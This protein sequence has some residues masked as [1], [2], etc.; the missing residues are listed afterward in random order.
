MK[1]LFFSPGYWQS[2]IQIGSHHLARSL[3]SLGW[4]VGF[5]SDPIT[6][7]HLFSPRS[8]HLATRFKS[9]I[10]GGI[11][12][13]VWN[14]V[15][16][17]LFAPCPAPILNSLAVASHWN[18]FSIPNIFSVL[19]RTGFDSVDLV[20]FDHP[21][22]ALWAHQIKY[23]KSVFRIPDLFSGFE[24]YTRS[25]G[26]L[27]SR[28][29][30]IVDLVVYPSSSLKSHIDSLRPNA[31]LC[32][33]NGVDLR[34]FTHLDKLERPIEFKGITSPIVLYVGAID[35]WFDAE[36]FNFASS[37]LSDCNFFLIGE[38]KIGKRIQKNK[39]VHL[40]GPKP[41]DQI[42]SYLR[43]STAGIIP[44]DIN[45]HFDFVRHI[46]PLKLYEYLISGLPV[47]STKWPALEEMKSPARLVTN[48]KD[49]VTEIERSL[50]MSFDEREKLRAFA[51]GQDWGDRTKILLT[52][53]GFTQ[54]I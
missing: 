26:V 34:S 20:Y 25:Q 32:L 48:A 9:Y 21:N 27:E 23:K 49:F 44:F 5:V 53:L 12:S 39:N 1:A 6:P 8:T 16:G 47:V 2:P 28:L 33:P 14:Y 40:L 50:K 43:H 51:H 37:T 36:L 17:A 24:K 4:T 46:Q 3:S 22:Q 11:T 52:A 18:R 19:K 10:R 35:K 31:S 54:N 15:P 13:R 42:P 30:Q 45:Q 41:H 29:A 38:N 7:L